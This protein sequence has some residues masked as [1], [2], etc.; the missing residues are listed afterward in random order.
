M[1]SEEPIILHSASFFCS[2]EA[3]EEAVVKPD[4][5]LPSINNRR[6]SLLWECEVELK[7]CTKA[8]EVRVFLES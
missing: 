4:S 7:F 6:F 2:V 3:E 5:K 1:V 8:N